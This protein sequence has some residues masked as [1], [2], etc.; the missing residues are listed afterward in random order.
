MLE[1]TVGFIGGGRITRIILE[2]WAKKSKMFKEVTVSDSDSDVLEKLKVQFPEIT[3]V[4][5]DNYKAAE[6]DI[7]FLAVHPP[8]VGE[9]LVGIKDS[10]TKDTVCISFI[11]KIKISMLS[12]KL[13]GI[14]NIVR[15]I[16]NACSII[17]EG[18]NPL[19]FALDCSSVVKTELLDLF[20]ILGE[21]PEVDE[22][23]LEA[24]A[25]ISAMG[26]TYFWFQLQTLRNLGQSFGLEKD[27]VDRAI[28]KMMQ[29]SLK[30]LLESGM[31]YAEVNDLIPV[32]PLGENIPAIQ[33]AY[34]EKLGG[35][36]KKLT[37]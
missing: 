18:Y 31:E 8:A 21:C 26:P 37:G 23:H 35:L 25:I 16:P 9:V 10:V 4:L 5:N 17:N 6:Q 30:T 27:A 15:L 34:E 36:Y 11:P 19:S 22:K 13:G 12:E 33:K 29:G 7:L 3:T 24:Y 20:A 14:N 28:S 1:K 32:K 2:G